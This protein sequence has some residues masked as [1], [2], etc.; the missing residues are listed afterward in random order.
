MSKICKGCGNKIPRKI[1]HAD[2]KTKQSRQKCYNCA[3]IRKDPHPIEH[4]SERRK[5]KSI[6]IKMLGGCCVE[7][8]YK[9]SITALS[10]HHKDPKTKLFDISNGHMMSDW[11]SVVKEAKK[12]EILCLNCHS[13]FNDKQAR[14]K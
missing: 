12:C 1:P 3:P 2:K 4:R 6:L 11:D 7:C 13:E 5:R 9:K 14:R 10:F 8:G